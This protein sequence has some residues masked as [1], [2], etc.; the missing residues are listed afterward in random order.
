ME[1]LLEMP[2]LRVWKK[3]NRRIFFRLKRALSKQTHCSCFFVLFF[4]FSC[5]LC[6]C[7]FFL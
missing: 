6:V 5:W 3:R 7:V 2:D 1:E 4:L